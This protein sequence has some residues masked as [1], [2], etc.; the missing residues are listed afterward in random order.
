[1]KVITWFFFLRAFFK[2]NFAP[3]L[4]NSYIP[5]FIYVSL[6]C[7]ILMLLKYQRGLRATWHWILPSPVELVPNSIRVCYKLGGGYFRLHKDPVLSW[8]T[9]VE[10]VLISL[11]FGFHADAQANG[12]EDIHLSTHY[13]PVPLQVFHHKSRTLWVCGPW[14]LTPV[15]HAKR[16]FT[17]CRCQVRQWDGAPIWEG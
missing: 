16:E 15:K 14:V 10:S 7:Y 1:M 3:I 6:I 4:Y 13:R 12:R 11:P 5:K 9:I 8:T 2:K 17:K